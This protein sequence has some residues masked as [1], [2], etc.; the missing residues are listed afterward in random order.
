[1]N[2]FNYI[3]SFQVNTNRMTTFTLLESWSVLPNLPLN[4]NLQHRNTPA[5]QPPHHLYY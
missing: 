5:F 4:T 3:I 1:M 2:I